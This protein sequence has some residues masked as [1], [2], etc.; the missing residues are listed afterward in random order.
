[1]LYATCEI[2]LSPLITGLN[3]DDDLASER[4]AMVTAWPVSKSTEW[5]GRKPARVVPAIAKRLL[6]PYLTDGGSGSS[7][8]LV[9]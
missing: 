4:R 7:A 3:S 2:A 1:M 8:R 6:G 9:P 5:D